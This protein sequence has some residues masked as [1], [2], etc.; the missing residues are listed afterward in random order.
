MTKLKYFQI[1]NILN[2]EIL[3]YLVTFWKSYVIILNPHLIC[4]G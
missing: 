2:L 1:K 4:I 3:F